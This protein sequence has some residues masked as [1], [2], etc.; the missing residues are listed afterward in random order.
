M[1]Q[2]K[3]TV[4]KEQDGS[5]SLYLLHDGLSGSEHRAG[6]GS[7]AENP[8]ASDFYGQLEQVRKDYESQGIVVTFSDET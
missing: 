6:P 3:L 2:V 7:L 5:L 4:R 1:K 8:D